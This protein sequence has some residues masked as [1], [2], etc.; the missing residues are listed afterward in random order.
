MQQLILLIYIG[1]AIK[2]FPYT[3][4]IFKGRPSIIMLSC[5]TVLDIR[6]I[7]KSVITI[8]KNNRYCNYYN[9]ITCKQR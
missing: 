7:V 4:N 9:H 5:G 8:I 1:N 6:P 3:Y 2:R